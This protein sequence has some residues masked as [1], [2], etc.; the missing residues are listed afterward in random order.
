MYPRRTVLYLTLAHW[1]VDET[2]AGSTIKL[3]ENAIYETVLALFY[4]IITSDWKKLVEDE[5]ADDG[6]GNVE[7]VE[8]L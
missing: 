4:P 1:L 6:D 2:K 5:L 3:L 7:T 8:V